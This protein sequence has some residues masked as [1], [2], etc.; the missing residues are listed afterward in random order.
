MELP[1]IYYPGYVAKTDGKRLEIKPSQDMGLVEVTVPAGAKQRTVEVHYGMTTA[2]K[3][4]LGISVL[5]VVGCAVM[6]V[7]RRQARSMTR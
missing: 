4:G 3:V 2:T 5:T 7:R 1:L 6:S